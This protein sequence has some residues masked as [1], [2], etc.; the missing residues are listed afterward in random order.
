MDWWWF[1]WVGVIKVNQ[2]WDVLLFIYYYLFVV[3]GEVHYNCGS[4][5]GWV[6]LLFRCNGLYI[7]YWLSVT[8]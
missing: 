1:K 3:I 2:Y 5:L 4:R 8:V 7:G 6:D